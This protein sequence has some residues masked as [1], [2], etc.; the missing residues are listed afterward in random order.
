VLAGH[1]K[2]VVTGG[3]GFVGGHLVQALLSL[4]KDVTVVDNGAT[5]SEGELQ[6]GATLVKADITDPRQVREALAG[7][8][9][10]FHLA[11][12]SS[13]TRSVFEPRFDFETNAVGTFN[14]LEGSVHAGVRRLLYVSSASVYGVPRRFPMAEDHPTR[15]FVPYGAS[16]LGGELASLA[17]CHAVG[18]PVVVARP[19][20]IYGPGENPDIALVEPTRYL[21][22]HLNGLPIEVVGDP[23]R[24]TRDFVHV[25]DIVAALVLIADRAPTGEVY[26]VGSGDEV[27]MRELASIVGD[28]T[29]RPASVMELREVTQDTYRLVGDIAKLR[30]L[31]YAPRMSLFDGV[32]ALARVL[33]DAPDLPR[34]A[35]VFEI[36]Q[37]AEHVV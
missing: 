20:C 19:F 34:G 13:G 18:L 32:Q 1:T 11:G 16:K 24:K 36:G 4:G 17:M 25:S 31:G 29:G 3:L 37:T 22:W 33:G 26:N 9:L 30:D 7:A 6:A 27:S 35:T 10:V 2:L 23:D 8:D 14:V 15:P 28:V 5:G 12:N 21:R